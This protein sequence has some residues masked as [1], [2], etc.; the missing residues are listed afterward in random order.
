MALAALVA[1]SDPAPALL[2]DADT[3]DAQADGGPDAPADAMEGGQPDAAPPGKLFAFTASGDGKIRVFAVDDGTGAWTAKGSVAGGAAPS[4]VAM[5]PMTSR[6]FAV[7]ESGGKVLS[8]A[9]DSTTGT[10]SP[11]GT[12][13]G[14]QGAG[15]THL[16][17]DAT[18]A[19]V[20]V[21][22]YTA[23]SAAVFPILPNGSLGA[24]T[25]VE[26]PGVKAHLAITNPSGGFAFVPCLGSNVIAQ[27]TFDAILGKLTPNAPATVSASAAAG[28]RHLAFHPTEKFAYGVNETASTMSAYAF[29]IGT[30]TLTLVQT[31][32]TLPSNFAGPNSGAEVATSPSGAFVYASNRGHDSIV[33]FAVNAGTGQLTLVGHEPTGGKNPRSFAVD[34]AG[35][36]LFVANQGSGTVTGFRLDPTTGKPAP[37]PGPANLVPSPTFV[38]A[39]RIP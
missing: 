26:S 25:D 18:T 27:Y 24:P 20:L 30:G 8:F 28:P 13:I 4:F 2:A 32:S 15:P 33:T 14:S 10:L 29:D 31:Q 38:G 21:A 34:P 11:I 6:V 5:D 39:W 9:F 23:G 19:W 7:D 1:C 12:P 35:A 16:S 36:F 37:L 17:I 22:N 3:A